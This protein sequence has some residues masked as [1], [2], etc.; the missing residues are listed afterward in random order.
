MVEF[1]SQKKSTNSSMM[2][3]VA[4]FRAGQ[5]T[6]VQLPLHCY[7]QNIP[8]KKNSLEGKSLFWL[9]FSER[10][11]PTMAGKTWHWKCVM[12]DSYS[13]NGEPGTRDRA[14]TNTYFCS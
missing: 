9:M 2:A 14:M 3:C 12:D 1:Q 4:S 6:C 8:K 11:Q 10:F 13:Y 5:T 7:D